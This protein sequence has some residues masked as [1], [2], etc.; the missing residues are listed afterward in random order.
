L[1]FGTLAMMGAAGQQDVRLGQ[2]SEKYESGGRGPATV[3]SGIGEPGGVSYGTYQLA[4]KIGRADQF[5]RQYY[6]ARFQGLTAGS[7]AFTQQ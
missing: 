1:L 7:E 3:S 5:V 6:P 2:L 4:S